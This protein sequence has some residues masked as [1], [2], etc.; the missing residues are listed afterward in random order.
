[1]TIIFYLSVKLW[2]LT[3]TWSHIYDNYWKK[4]VLLRASNSSWE[5]T[6]D[7]SS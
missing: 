5:D 6:K 3:L 4:S 1:M 2:L 7:V